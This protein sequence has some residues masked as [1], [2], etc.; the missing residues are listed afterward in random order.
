MGCWSCSNGSNGKVEMNPVRPKVADEA[1][2]KG[3]KDLGWAG[4]RPSRRAVQWEGRKVRERGLNGSM[5]VGITV[6]HESNSD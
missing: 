6:A 5:L 4:T 3:L 2:H 1:I